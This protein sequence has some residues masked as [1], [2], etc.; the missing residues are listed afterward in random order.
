MFSAGM[1]SI[2][3]GLQVG[4]P[5]R[6]RRLASLF[7]AT[8]EDHSHSTGVAKKAGFEIGM[9]IYARFDTP[10][11]IKLVFDIVSIDGDTMKLIS[12]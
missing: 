2:R 4:L 7:A 8:L 6:T 5:K 1:S 11:T 3:V 10:A 9:S 12:K